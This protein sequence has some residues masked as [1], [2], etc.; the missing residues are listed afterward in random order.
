MFATLCAL[1]LLWTQGAS[2]QRI[3]KF[4]DEPPINGV[5]RA[6]LR[7]F[8]FYQPRVYPNNN[9]P[10]NHWFDALNEARQ[11]PTIEP[12]APNFGLQ[13][14]GSWEFMGPYTTNNSWLGRVNA[15]IVDR[16]NASTIYA[17]VAKGG[18]WKSTDAG[19]TWT[20]LTDNITQYVGCLAQDPVNAN[21]IY[22]GTGE[23]YFAVNTFGGVGI[24]KSING[25]ATWTLFG[26]ST[27]AGRRINQIVIDPTDTN[28]WIVSSDNGIYVTTNGGTSF[29]QTLGGVASALRMHPTNSSILYAALGY[30]FQVTAANG[31]YKSING[32]TTWVKLAGG[33]P[34]S[35]TMGRIELDF[36]KAN[37]N[38]V[39]V[40]I[41]G[42]YPLTY[43]GKTTD[44]GAT[45]T[46]LPLPATSRDTWYNLLI[47][48]HPTDPN[49]AYLGIVDL[50][51][52]TNSGTSWSTITPN[53]PDMHTLEFNPTDPQTIYLGQDAG[54]FVSANGGTSWAA[55]NNGRGTMEYYAF[56]VHPT[57]PLRLA[58]GA[59]DNST[60]VRTGTNS[61][62]VVIGGDGFW[63]AYKKTNPLV[64]LG[65]YQN[66]NIFRS[67]DGGTS[68]S[69]VHNAVGDW[70]TPIIN[71]PTTPT[72]FYAGNSQ[73][74]RSNT[75]GASGTWAPI[76]GNLTRTGNSTL[77]RIA[78]AP[79]N[80]NVVYTGA[81]DGGLF[82]STDATVAVPTWTNR[83]AGLP[84]AAIGGIAV[85]PANPNIVYVGLMGY[86][87]NH[88]MKSINGGATWTNY[89]GNLP[90]AAVTGVV[91]N[92][93]NTAQLLAATDAGVFLTSDGVAWAKYGTELPTTP[94]THLVANATT[95]YLTV[96]TYG[97]GMWRILLPG[98]NPLPILTSI[99]PNAKPIG[100]AAFTLTLT[101]S[102]F[103]PASIV[104]W[105]GVSRPTTYVSLTQLTAAIPASDLTVGGTA[106]VTVFNPAPFGGTSASKLFNINATSFA[107]TTLGSLVYNR[108][109]DG[110][111][112]TALSSTANATPY[113]V[114][115]V[116]VPTSGIYNFDVT[117]TTGGYDPCTALYSGSFNPSTPLINVI[118]ANDNKPTAANSGFDN[119]AL[120]SGVEYFLVVSG[121]D[122]ADSGNFTGTVSGVGSATVAPLRFVK[123]T[124]TLTGRLPAAY[125]ATMAFRFTP[126][127]DPVFSLTV[128]L[129]AG[130]AFTLINLPADSYALAA[131]G[132]L[133]LRKSVA[134]NVSAA[135]AAGVALSLPGGDANNN[136]VANIS[137]LLILIAAYNTSSP[138][139]GYN[140]NAD[141]NGD[142]SD[143]ISD[144]LILIAS[145]NQAGVP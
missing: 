54:L 66:G 10:A 56:D 3:P 121:F 87:I 117:T 108:T 101:G 98:V 100:S 136:N 7:L 77:S 25:G 51:K 133:W 63:T 112:P 32:G 9:L 37:P 125:P 55:K 137:D 85:D 116:T 17:G 97:R 48:A 106:N 47:R 18:V 34:A 145:Y 138:N 141:F 67:L 26:N 111:P 33:L 57:D 96:S 44:V 30:P 38:I 118:A 143:D 81:N 15:I 8:H 13:S 64:M 22:M 89:S 27:F 52:T 80:A 103:I 69:F 130:G 42:F 86:N 127:S 6:W 62:N 53:H 59:Q 102:D 75:D 39:Y 65:E 120:N 49:T 14:L 144:L 113:S 78:V 43:V 128:P 12:D 109:N 142:G 131:K 83:S 19:T 84:T 95:G 21:T 45:W 40:A 107:G 124:L 16:T 119:I 82:L 58:A 99:S 31:V 90:N 139:A 11:L 72:R 132:N 23:E 2:A 123:G 61:F 74:I 70:S 115:K 88:V 91:V 20:G 76:S 71:D 24:Y 135:N 129:G 28:K 1:F 35:N 110:L 93:V 134:V 4:W 5:P 122:N 60:H 41:G 46:S 105:N 140:P 50:Y 114:F 68:W 29:I 104:R 94:C 73:L 92:P 126:S 36:H 79:S